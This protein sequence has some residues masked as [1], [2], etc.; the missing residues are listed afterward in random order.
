M[1]N[2]CLYIIYVENEYPNQF[3]DLPLPWQR[4]NVRSSFLVVLLNSNTSPPVPAAIVF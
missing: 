1:V 3:E 4:P 2:Y